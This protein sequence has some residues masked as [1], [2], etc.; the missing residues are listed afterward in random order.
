MRIFYNTTIRPELMRMER[1]RRRTLI[2]IGLSILGLIIVGI[3][4]VAINA[5][6]VVLIAAAPIVFYLGT[7]YFRIEKFRQKFKPA[8]VSLVLEFMNLATNFQELTYDAKKMVAK[9]RFLRSE[10]FVGRSAS[11]AGEDYIKGIVGEMPFELSEIYVQ[12]VSKASNRLELIF[13][14]IFIHALFNEPTVGHLAVWPRSEYRYLRRTLKEFIY[15]GGF[16]AEKE[17]Q[18]PRFREL[19]VV[20]AKKDTVVHHILTEP[21]QESLVEFV[22]QTGHELYFSIHDKDV[23]A[24]ISHD[25]DL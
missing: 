2:G 22:D 9:D 16:D 3:I 12:E 15:R 4:F 24:G 17:I 25:R 5:G 1:V 8:V 20:Y 7:L 10:L 14:G 23:F 18:N 13:G 6:F 19:F 11:Y 21:M